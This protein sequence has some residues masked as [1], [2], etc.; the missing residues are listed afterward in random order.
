MNVDIDESLRVCGVPREQAEEF[1]RI[2]TTKK[3]GMHQDLGIFFG[4]HNTVSSYL[5]ITLA[6]IC[7]T[8]LV[9]GG[10]ITPECV[11]ERGTFCDENDP[12]T[13]KTPLFK[14]L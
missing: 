3:W 12:N 1:A 6:V 14:S 4:R 5:C 13:W 8:A 2:L 9:K 7:G 11:I 10:N